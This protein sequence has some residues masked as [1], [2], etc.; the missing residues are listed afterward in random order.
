[1]DMFKKQRRGLV[2]PLLVLLVSALFAS[3]AAA[4]CSPNGTAGNDDITCTGTHTQPVNTSTGNDIV[5]IEGQVLRVITHTGDSLTVI[6]AP[7]G[8]L[9]TTSPTNDAIRFTGSGSV[10]TQGDI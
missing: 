1:E 9:D 4:Q 2:A 3:P 5:R 6:I 10:T 8:R 7:G